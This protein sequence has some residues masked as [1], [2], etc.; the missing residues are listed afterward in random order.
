MVD[1]LPNKLKL[2]LN[3]HVIVILKALQCDLIINTIPF[4]PYI[5][6]TLQFH[7]SCLHLTFILQFLLP[8]LYL[9]FTLLYFLFAITSPLTFTL[10]PP[11]FLA[12]VF[13]SLSIYFKFTIP[14]S[15]GLPLRRFRNSTAPQ[16]IPEIALSQSNDATPGPTGELERQID[17]GK[18]F[19]LS[20]TITLALVITA[21][22]AV[23]VYLRRWLVSQFDDDL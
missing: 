13:P 21:I 18:K 22:V 1:W 2:K 8:Q 4:S 19:L 14:L 7:I 11:Y 10:F 6:I 3:H 15:S 9:S 20:Y 23:I 17:V 16:S 5:H 12:S